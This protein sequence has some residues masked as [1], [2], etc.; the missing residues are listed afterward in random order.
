M[1]L[2]SPNHLT[3]TS[4]HPRI[5]SLVLP[6]LLTI[7]VFFFMINRGSCESHSQVERPIIVVVYN[8]PYS[9]FTKKTHSLKNA[10]M[11]LEACVMHP[12]YKTVSNS[13]CTILCSQCTIDSSR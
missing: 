9:Y 11:H 5:F 12:S 10:F 2:H 1:V 4:T 8:F 7:N 13:N 6:T 3:S